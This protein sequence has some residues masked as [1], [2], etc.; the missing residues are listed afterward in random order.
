V[1]AWRAAPKRSVL[2]E[3]HEA[4]LVLEQDPAAGRYGLVEGVGKLFVF[5]RLDNDQADL[6]TLVIEVAG[7]VVGSAV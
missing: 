3:G 5:A 1:N 7:A 6:D 2:V 4:L